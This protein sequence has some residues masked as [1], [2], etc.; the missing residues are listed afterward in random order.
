MRT[1][2]DYADELPDTLP[3]DDLA[4]GVPD[5][6]SEDSDI[7]EP[8]PLDAPPAHESAA[9]AG[10]SRLAHGLP[11]HGGATTPAARGQQVRPNSIINR[12]QAA[13]PPAARVEAMAMPGSS[14]T[15][16]SSSPDDLYYAVQW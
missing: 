3:L 4:D 1:L 2:D 14:G 7:D 15:D 13:G 16:V 9:I 5:S 8:M 6:A 12:A 11:T 10:P